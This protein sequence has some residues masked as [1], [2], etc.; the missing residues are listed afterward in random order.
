MKESF[1]FEDNLNE[2][3]QQT[4]EFFKTYID[5]IDGQFK[6]YILNSTRIFNIPKY[7][8]VLLTSS[9]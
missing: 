5:D 4:V 3:Q 9:Q 1:S 8:I 7:P 6:C 2:E